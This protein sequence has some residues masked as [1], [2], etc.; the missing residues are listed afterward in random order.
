VP[1]GAATPAQQTLGLE[2]A[3]VPIA[4]SVACSKL[5]VEELRVRY[6]VLNCGA[7]QI[8]D[9][10]NR[11][12]DGGHYRVDDSCSP[13]RLDITGTTGPN[14][15]RAMLA[16]YRLRGDELTVAY[17]LERAARPAHL[18]PR[19]DQPLLRITYARAALAFS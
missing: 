14:A 5:A 4:A 11:V 8:I 2:G 17:D 12:V 6:L 13:P 15:G 3:W 10:S 19:P 1:A 18:T 9:R 7:Y 16:I